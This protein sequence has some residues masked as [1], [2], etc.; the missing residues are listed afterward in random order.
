MVKL[1]HRVEHLR[2]VIPKRPKHDKQDTKQNQEFW[3]KLYLTLNSEQ[4]QAFEL[5]IDKMNKPTICDE[6]G[7]P[8]DF[9]D[10]QLQKAIRIFD[11]ALDNFKNQ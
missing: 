9:G 1:I 8:E 4:K 3:N 10:T 7:I 6:H 11:A 2:Q 5:I